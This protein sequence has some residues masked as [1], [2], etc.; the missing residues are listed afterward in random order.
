MTLGFLAGFRDGKCNITTPFPTA[1]PPASRWIQ[2]TSELHFQLILQ[3]LSLPGDPY[4]FTCY[5][6]SVACRCNK[7]LPVGCLEC[8]KQRAES[9]E[10]EAGRLPAKGE[11]CWTQAGDPGVPAS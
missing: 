11:K 8:L 3:L 4:L 5:C 9:L 2:H 1:P 10:E 7:E 6:R